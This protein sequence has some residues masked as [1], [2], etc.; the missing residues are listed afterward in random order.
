MPFLS[1]RQPAMFKDYSQYDATGLAEL[2]ARRDVSAA[3][4]LE[5]AIARAEAVNPKI[6]AICTPMHDIAHRRAQEPLTGAF[7]GVPMLIKDIA[8]HHAGVPTS[9]GSRALRHWLPAGHSEYV[10]RLLGAGTVIFGKTTTPEY[11]L[12]GYTES[13]AL[14]A[15]RNPWNLE[16]TTGGSSGGAAA[17]VAAG[18]VPMAGASDGGGSIRIPASYCG[19]FGLR[20]GRG[21][22]SPGPDHDEIW[23][24]ASQEHVLSRSVRDSARMLDVLAGRDTGAP[25]VI[26]PPERPYAEEV[27]REPGRLRIG[28][29]TASPLGTPVDADC[30]RAVEDAAALLARLGHHVEQAAPAI[31]GKALARSYLS[32]YMGQT[33]AWM[34]EAKALTGASDEDFELDTRALA[35]LGQA[36]SAGEYV[37]Q[38]K[39]WNDY[40]RALGQFHERFDLYL[41]PTV[42]M[43]AARIG[44]QGLPL[45]QRAGLR[46]ILKL[47]AGKALLNSGI[48]DQMATQNLARVPFTQLSNLTGTPSMSVP[49]HTSGEGLPV[50]VQFIAASGGEGLLIRLAAQLESEAPW[51][52]R[53]PA[54]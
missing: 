20:P 48:V 26:A 16:R 40:M 54:V 23:D 1:T 27:G 15:T 41:T 44:E 9:A 14:G 52:D 51:R 46:V 29:S 19:L 37:T 43:P 53:L 33:A 24:G 13:A 38:R 8:Q 5:A 47:G 2:V 30:I 17:A 18:I 34:A 11:A 36:L 7:A 31:D 21:R 10:Q 6:N 50:G 45:V 42:A 3:E 49:L 4:L 32:M 22:V 25:F 12:K 39:R 35:L 28:F